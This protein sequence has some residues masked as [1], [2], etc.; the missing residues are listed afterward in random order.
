MMG[1]G[2]YGSSLSDQHSYER[3]FAWLPVVT[4]SRKRVWLKYYCIRH[5]YYDN[6][7]KPPIKGLCWN[8][9]FTENEYLMELLKNE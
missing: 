3:K 1:H 6:M 4:N 8:C 7:G 2:Y 9:I 5:T